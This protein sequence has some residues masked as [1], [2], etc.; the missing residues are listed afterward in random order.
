[1]DCLSMVRKLIA[2]TEICLVFVWNS[3]V[4]IPTLLLTHALYNSYAVRGRQG[5]HRLM[6]IS[7]SRNCVY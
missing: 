4:F 5:A 2:I 3:T 6:F 7:E 1:M